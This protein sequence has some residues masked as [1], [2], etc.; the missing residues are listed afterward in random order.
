MFT[1]YKRYKHQKRVHINKRRESHSNYSHEEKAD[2]LTNVFNSDTTKWY[3]RGASQ[4]DL[5]KNDTTKWNKRGASHPDAKEFYKIHCLV[6]DFNRKY[7]SS[8]DLKTHIHI[9]Q[10]HYIYC[11]HLL[12]R[13]CL[14]TLLFALGI[15]SP[16]LK[17]FF[18]SLSHSRT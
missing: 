17:H 18:S 3:K 7:Q 12:C 5:F 4:S 1:L 2:D 11:E 13:L 9:D 10:L 14:G 16:L 8:V 15:I 6:P